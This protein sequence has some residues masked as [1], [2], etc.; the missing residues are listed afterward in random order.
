[1]NTGESRASEVAS[2]VAGQIR[3][4]AERQRRALQDVGEVAGV[5]AARFERI[6]AG[7]PQAMTLFDLKAIADGLG[8]A[9][10]RLFEHG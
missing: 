5:A 1:M 4:I 2:V 7:D 3:T 8:V 6:L 9:L 10:H